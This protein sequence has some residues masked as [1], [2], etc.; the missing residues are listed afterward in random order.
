MP[1]AIAEVL[2]LRPDGGAV[3]LGTAFAVSRELALTA[4]HVVGDQRQAKV[5]D[6][7]FRLRFPGGHACGAT[8]TDGD[9]QLDFAL[10]A[11]VPPLPEG[12]RPIPLTD[13]AQEA[14]GFISRGFPPVTGVDQ[15]TVAGTIRNLHATIFGGVPA[16]QLFSHEAGAHMPLGGMSDAPVLVG[17]GSKQA[18]L[19]LIRWNPTRPDDPALSAGGTLFACPLSALVE[20]RPELR[21]LLLPVHEPPPRA[22]LHNLPFAPNPRFTGREA[23]METLHQKLGGSGATGAGSRVAVH[24]LGGVGKT[25][26]AVQYAWEHLREFDAVL[27]TRADGREALDAGVAAWAHVLGLPAPKEPKQDLRVKAVRDWLR[28]HGRWLL[29]A[30]NADDDEAAGAVWNQFTPD[31][32][33]CVVVTSRLDH[34]PVNVAHQLL[35]VLAPEDAAYYLQDRVGQEGHHAGGAD[36]AWKLAQELGHLPLA[37]EQA[38]SFVI[39]TRLS[40]DQ[41]REYFRDARPELLN[42]P[43]E[44]ATR[45]PVSVAKTWS[46][47]LERVSPAARALLRLAAWFAPEDIPRSIFKAERAPLAEALADG[48]AVSALAIDMAL[49]QLER[50][51]LIRLDTGN[52]SMHRLLQAVEQD[53]LAPEARAHW[54][55]RALELWDAYAAK[56]IDGLGVWNGLWPHGKTLLEHAREQEL[57]DLLVAR[58]ANR[59]G[60]FLLS[61]ARYADAESLFAQALAIRERALGP[62]HLDV[63]DSLFNL[64]KARAIEYNFKE[65]CEEA[66]ARVLAIRERTLGPE[67]LDVAEVL[68]TMADF[69]FDSAYSGE[70]MYRALKIS[71]RA[72]G[73]EDPK[74]TKIRETLASYHRHWNAMFNAG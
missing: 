39:Q 53:A 4:F 8:F 32:P 27:W 71:E 67:H 46:L 9:G 49:G 30:D 31:L 5:R 73:P 19:G 13:N 58:V 10:L 25:Q 60:T 14:E 45:Y 26:L 11:L 35:N 37:L 64:A 63:A 3:S 48:A 23:D 36:D 56:E 72:L 18:V 68:E 55:R 51:S 20:R 28:D 47:T 33:G 34:W 17:T 40:F 66:F 22:V 15:L 74:V 41:Y 42:R 16:I 29:I 62:E 65:F 44:G 61:H 12:L 38:A 43:A 54:L 52:F 7:P 59:M 50:F 57:D 1:E 70:L 2:K 69:Y 24:G 21:A 6:G